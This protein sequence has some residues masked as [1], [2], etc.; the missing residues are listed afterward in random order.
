MH[1]TDLYYQ[2]EQYTPRTRQL[3][4]EDVMNGCAV[5]PGGW[6][7]PNATST[8]TRV[9]LGKCNIPSETLLRMQNAFEN[10]NTRFAALFEQN[11]ESLYHKFFI[12]KQ[13][14]GRREINQP[15]PE[16]MNALNHLRYI[17]E[18]VCGAKYHTSAFAYIKGRCI[19]DLTAKHAWNQ[20]NWFLK[21]D[22]SGFFPSTT[23]DFV[24]R[25]LS[26]ISPFRFLIQQNREP[27]EKALSLAFLNGGL[28]QGSPVSPCISNLMMIPIDHE[29]FNFCASKRFVYTRYADDITISCQQTFDAKEM[30]NTIKSVLAKWNAPFTIKPEKT[31][32]VNNKGAN[33]MMGL[34]VNKD[35]QVTVGH[36]RKKYVKAALC[37]FIMDAKN[38]HPWTAEDATELQGTL[39]YYHMVEPEYFKY[40]IARMNAKFHVNTAT[41]LRQCI[42]GNLR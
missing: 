12:P 17:L 30:V 7:K 41:L 1:H 38:H 27:I 39:A 20:S 40:L 2:V 9:T 25:M 28:P 32:Y 6:Q 15:N 5:L 31:R 29:L 18:T 14:G 23:L 26:M 16:L 11:R 36:K 42:A 13:H 10:F 3:T 8:V 37:N 24:M 22:F 19:T 35:H 21:T 34:M 33:W 4:W